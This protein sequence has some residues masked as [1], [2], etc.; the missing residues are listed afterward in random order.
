MFFSLARLLDN[1]KNQNADMNIIKG[2]VFQTGSKQ[3]KQT[4][5]NKFE[6][7]QDPVLHKPQ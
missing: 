3:R 7:G 1:E 2:T 6:S 4:T 5:I